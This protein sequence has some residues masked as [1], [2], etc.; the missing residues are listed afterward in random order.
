MG[1]Q[2]VKVEGLLYDRDGRAIFSDGGYEAAVK[3]R[4]VA[5][6]SATGGIAI[7]AAATTGGHPTLWNPLGSGRIMEVLSLS[8][9]YV[10]GNNAPGGL[11]WNLV[12]NTGATAATGASSPILTATKVDV[13]SAM[14][15]G[16]VDS[17]L[18]FAPTVNTFTAAPTYGRPISLSLFTGVA[19]T[20]VAPFQMYEKYDR[21]NPLL[22]APGAAIC[23]VTSQATTTSL[24]R[25]TVMV[26]EHD[27]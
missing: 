20:A 27:E 19:A 5:A 1:N 2:E 6:S 18:Y 25:Y 4:V 21:N 7:I 13:E 8:V 14:I 24:L 16:V 26:E 9:A 10:S 12:K 11:A 23:L 15:G 3:G 17:K 22:I